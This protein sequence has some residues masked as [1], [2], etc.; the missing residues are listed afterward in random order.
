[1]RDDFVESIYQ[2]RSGVLWVG[3]QTGWLE[4]L[5]REGNQFT[6][7]HIS[8][9][10]F[11]IQEDT[12][13][14]LWIGSKDPGLLRFDRNTGQTTVAW[15]GKDFMSIIEDHTGLIWAT[16]PEEGVITYDRSSDQFTTHET[17]YPAHIVVEDQTGTIWIGT[18]GGGLGR[19]DR[20]TNEFDYLRNHPG[21]PNSLSNDYVSSIHEDASGDLWIGTYESG[22]NRYRRESGQFARYQ[23]NPSDR[24]SLSTNTI[25]SIYEDR[26]GVLWIGHAIGGSISRMPV[27]VESFGHY[28]SIPN[29]P[30]SLSSSVVTSIY[31]DREG[32]LWIGTFSGLDRWDPRTGQWTNYRHDPQDPNSLASDVV[33]SVYVDPT[34]T[35]WVGTEGG[36]D[37]HDRE[38]DR[39][40]HYDSPTVMWMHQGAS[41]TF[42]MATKG[43]LY[44]LDRER[45]E[46][47]LIA[48]GYAWKIMVLEDR[49]GILWV[50]S[51]GDGLDRYDPA[52]G[53]WRHYEHDPDDP[54]SLAD[55]FV[56]SIHEDGAGTLWIGTRGGLD[57]FDPQTETF[58]HYGLREGLADDS[59][60]GVLEDRQ[61]NLWLS[62][63]GGLS[64]FDPQ[65]ETCEN[66]SASDGLQ[67]DI[68]W[69]N[70]YY[71][72]PDGQMFFGGEN[73][74]NAFYPEQI[75]NNPHAPPVI[76]TAFS[77]FN[78]VRRSHLTANEQIELSYQDNFISF[79]FAALD[80]SAPQRNEYAYMLQ[81]LDEDWVVAG[82]RRHADYPNLRPGDYVFRVIGSNSDGVWN[83]ESSS[84]T[85]SI[86]P[87]FWST[88]WF[89]GV[90]LV[91][92]VVG[93]LGTYRLRVKRIET[94]SREL[95][96]QVER[97]T[98]ELQREIE[99]RAKVEEA[100]RRSEMEKAVAA[101]RSRL[102]REL[103]D[104]VTQ[105]LFSAS[106]IA[107]VLPRVW[108]I[109][110]EKG[111]QQLEEVRLLTRGAL[112]EMRTLLMEMRPES[113]SRARMDDL[114]R[115]LGRAVT[116]RTGVPVT[117]SAEGEWTFP[118]AVQIA[119][120]RIAQE[121]LNN[122]AK[123]AEASR[124]TV[125][126]ECQPG[127]VT[128]S[129]TDDGQG[130]NIASIPAD[131]LGLEI[132]RERAA[133]IDA[134]LK[135]ESQP[136]DGTQVRVLWIDH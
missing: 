37:Q 108:A 126:L 26:S 106:L 79:D 80:Y 134:Q 43:G 78:R 74:F 69:R 85:I 65:T 7:Y 107:E 57:R 93:L 47:V 2:D 124:V 50:G 4:R 119:L 75:V 51:S 39:F 90:A 54:T 32:V 100:L 95:E 62:T 31:G 121:A 19:F 111:R 16:S 8:S 60:L 132:M 18:W 77:V 110:Q 12:E 49:A 136:G 52:G 103:H 9:H 99:Q 89:R 13:G 44:Q 133:A 33:R 63:N 91:A 38:R 17:D 61:G 104:A 29:N 40:I 96:E 34:N 15:R 68:F 94:R 1:L 23:H 24:H 130:F 30:Q 120:Y 125:R 42:W 3:T 86:R 10:V 117:V 21:D 66:Y 70:A 59:V 27:G 35:L 11:A 41:G 5:D 58:T 115:Q 6:H 112:A 97:R 105:T 81:G 116:G 88:W 87:P 20:E 55:D 113:L 56:E 53:E 76:I 46:L 14:V 135:I 22:L 64:R 45:D 127:L 109:D 83:Q 72:S 71:Q 25:L 82:T 118:P 48:Q 67:S 129:I 98:A 122:V 28:Q 131:R 114:L 123:H 84:V 36:L 73:G 101:E 102:A 92:V 128:L